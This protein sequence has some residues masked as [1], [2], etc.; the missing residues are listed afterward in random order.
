MEGSGWSVLI[1]AGVASS[2]TADSFLKASHLTRTR[3]AHQV[4]ALALGKLQEDAYLHAHTDE[5]K[6]VETE[7]DPK[8][9]NIPVP[10]YDTQHGTF[11][12][13]FHQIAS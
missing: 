11:G 10:G 4:T 8:E 2:G 1:Q 13:H 6:E 12:P 7:N 5:T 9:S 3:H